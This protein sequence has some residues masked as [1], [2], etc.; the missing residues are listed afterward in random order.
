MVT[1]D[2][3]AMSAAWDAAAGAAAA[4][5]HDEDEGAEGR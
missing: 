2:V 5:M 1:L 3:S 4:C